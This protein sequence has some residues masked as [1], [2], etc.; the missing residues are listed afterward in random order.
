MRRL[1]AKRRLWCL[2]IA[3]AALFCLAPLLY[4]WVDPYYRIRKGMTGQEVERVLGP[5][6]FAGVETFRSLDMAADYFTEIRYR[7]WDVLTIRYRKDWVV[8]KGRAV[9]TMAELWQEVL[10]KIGWNTAPR[11]VQFPPVPPTDWILE[12]APSPKSPD[13]ETP[14]RTVPP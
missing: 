1:I 11:P 7:S 13:I 14:T 4:F 12:R 6:H 3:L 2:A 5:A 9:T 8:E 10:Y